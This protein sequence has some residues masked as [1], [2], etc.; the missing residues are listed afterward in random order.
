MADR[1]SNFG[2]SLESPYEDGVAVTPSDSTVLDTTRAL[3]IGGAG[4]VAVVTK[5]GTTLTFS[6]VPVGTVL[7]LRVTK[8]MA[9][10][11]TATNILA[12]Y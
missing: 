7:R 5:G 12:L 11:T 6:A 3:Y 9:T 4:A 1:F 8:V 10:N 2:A